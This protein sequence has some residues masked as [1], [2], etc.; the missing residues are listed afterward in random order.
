MLVQPLEVA[1]VAWGQCGGVAESKT[2]P[3]VQDLTEHAQRQEHLKSLTPRLQQRL[4]LR[5]RFENVRM[6]RTRAAKADRGG[7]HVFY[8]SSCIMHSW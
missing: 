5:A 3:R 7:V 6:L 8:I 1:V 4:Q 2:T